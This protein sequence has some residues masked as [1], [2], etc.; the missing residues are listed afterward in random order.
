MKLRNGGK[1]TR[2][3]MLSD[4]LAAGSL[5][6]AT[7]VGR[8]TG[9]A[10][11]KLQQQEPTFRVVKP[12]GESPVKM[13]S[14][15]P[16]LDT[17]DGKTIA[18]VTNRLFKYEV[19]FPVIEQLLKKNYPN[20]KVISFEEF[21]VISNAELAVELRAKAIQLLGDQLLKRG[22]QAVISGNGG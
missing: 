10:E 20:S 1:L 11:Q 15:A 17:L 7:L 22:C 8:D 4:G 5:L 6:G 16:R 13:I 21:H 18:F 9:V 19:T 14:M 12:M 2:R 3:K